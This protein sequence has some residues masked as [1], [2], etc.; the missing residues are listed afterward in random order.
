MSEALAYRWEPEPFRP[1]WW[2]PGPH[3]QSAWVLARRKRALVRF[4][5]ERLETPDGDE[6][7]LDHVD[8]ASG[9]P[10]V[11]LLHGLEG[12]SSSWHMQEMARAMTRRGW[13]VTAL[14]FRSC[15]REL[16]PGGRGLPNRTSR[17]YHSGETEDLGLAIR[18]LV[19]R[20]PGTLLA[21]YGI[22][23]G[24]NVLLKW[25]GETGSA[26]GLAGAVAVSVPFDL[27]AAARN[28]ESPIGLL[29]THYYLS[30]L[31]PKFASVVARH[32]ESGARVDLARACRARTFFEFDDAAVAPLHGF[33]GALDYYMR[34]SS[35]GF[36]ER[37]AVPTLA[38]GS[39]DDPFS[40]P[41]VL[42]RV[43]ER[44]PAAMEL[45][46]TRAGGHVGFITGAA[47][48]RAEGWHVSTAADWLARL[49]KAKMRDTRLIF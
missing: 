4:R 6:L 19:D 40:P 10:R 9:S 23:L 47:P 42:A 15:A 44:A 27:H 35:L 3:L 45:H 16:E 41:A 7:V 20:E 34:S 2:L 17:L 43:R 5:R 48:W 24:G 49:L 32:P 38:L 22:S 30:S 21:A 46:L 39:S 31:R 29:Y 36:L 13:R 37:I 28:L 11:L 8:G 25:L 12:S 33:E 26:G 18:T 14:N 1:A